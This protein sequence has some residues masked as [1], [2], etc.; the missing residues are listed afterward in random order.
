MF[1]HHICVTN[2]SHGSG[3]DLAKNCIGDILFPQTI[4]HL[5]AQHIEFLVELLGVVNSI[6]KISIFFSF[7][8]SKVIF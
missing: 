2:E 1:G 4:D 8:K 6:L 5:L 3:W 7:R